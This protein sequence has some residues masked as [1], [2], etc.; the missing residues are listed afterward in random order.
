MPI[1]ERDKSR[2]LVRGVKTKRTDY[3]D[4]FMAWR[5]VV[6]KA[7]KREGS[8]QETGNE[9]LLGKKQN[10]VIAENEECSNKKRVYN[11]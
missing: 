6:N 2:G 11:V 5:W 9:E 8:G 7:G 1:W 10:I 4:C 3:F